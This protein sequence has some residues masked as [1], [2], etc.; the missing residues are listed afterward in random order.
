MIIGYEEDKELIATDDLV[1]DHYIKFNSVEFLNLLSQL[2]I[3][4]GNNP[5]K[6]PLD[7]FIFEEMYRKMQE[8]VKY[9]SNDQKSYE[10]K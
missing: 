9:T 1:F 2:E 7:K 10:I 8:L 6:L 4:V 5:A 3:L